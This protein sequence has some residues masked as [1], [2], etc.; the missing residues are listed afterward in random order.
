MLVC[1]YYCCEYKILSPGFCYPP[2][3]PIFNL[4]V[5]IA[6]T[7]HLH[8]FCANTL[9]YIPRSCWVGTY[10]NLNNFRQERTSREDMGTGL[11]PF[12]SACWKFSTLKHNRTWL[13]TVPG[14]L[15]KVNGACCISTLCRVYHNV[16]AQCTVATQRERG[17]VEI[18]HI[19]V[20]I[21]MK[22]CTGWKGTQS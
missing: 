14:T 8:V 12:E 6:Y 1:C 18:S 21:P 4:F 2:I 5:W 13:G 16:L 11:V 15:V 9:Y 3:F 7:K 10:K 20:Y 17:I 19:Y 22:H